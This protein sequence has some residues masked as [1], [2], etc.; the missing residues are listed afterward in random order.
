MILDRALIVANSSY[1]CEPQKLRPAH[2]E[3]IT[4]NALKSNTTT[5]TTQYTAGLTLTLNLT[6][7]RILTLA[8]TPNTNP[9]VPVLHV[10]E[11][12]G[13]CV[14]IGRALI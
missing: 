6:L 4:H 8:P 10:L 9:S 12:Q 13:A 1:G 3:E 11:L 5:T 2:A 14:S 7:T